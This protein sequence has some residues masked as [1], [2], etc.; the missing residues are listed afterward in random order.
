MLLDYWTIF[1]LIIVCLVIA[2]HH[3]TNNHDHIIS[4]SSVFGT[5]LLLNTEESDISIEDENLGTVSWFKGIFDLKL[6]IS[7]SKSSINSNDLSVEKDTLS[8]ISHYRII[9]RTKLSIE[10]TLIGDEGFYTLKI[11]TELNTYRQYTYHVRCLG[12]LK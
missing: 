11:R 3:N 4:I 6:L 10:Q 5:Q 8:N 12:S 7:N 1:L 9:N 2:E